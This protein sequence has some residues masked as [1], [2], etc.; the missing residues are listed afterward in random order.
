MLSSLL[1]IYI[2]SSLNTS[3][4]SPESYPLPSYAQNSMATPDI[5]LSSFFEKSKPPIKNPQQIAPIIEAGAAIVIDRTSGEILFEKD[6]NDRMGIASITKLMT[7]LIVLEENELG[8]NVTISGNA[9]AVEGSNMSLHTG[10]QISVESLIKAAIISSAN[11]A[12][13]ALAEYNVK[14]INRDAIVP[15]NPYA[16]GTVGDFVNKMNKRASELG[17]ENTH[18]S[19][20]AGLDHPENYSSAY[21]LAKLANFIYNNKFIQNIAV[22]KETDVLSA[23][24]QYTHNLKTTNELLDS[25]LKV[26]GLK[27]GTTE[28]AGLCMVAVAENNEGHEIITVVLDSPARFKESTILI[29][30]IFRS[31]T[32]PEA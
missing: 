29:D 26:K 19:N 15:E 8:E 3:T 7:V 24:G 6:A 17:L 18:Y 10:E 30:W 13:V 28:G 12:A 1:S 27:T 5:K 25:Y 23:D 11:D 2:A 14:D 32:W 31:Y 4:Q 16:A 9:N 22:I 20:P 21:D